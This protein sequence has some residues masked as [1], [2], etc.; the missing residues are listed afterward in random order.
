MERPADSGSGAQ[1]AAPHKLC[2]GL[3]PFSWLQLRRP[4]MQ[5]QEVAQA[6]TRASA[7]VATHVWSALK[8]SVPACMKSNNTGSKR[9]EFAAPVSGRYMPQEVIAAW[10]LPRLQAR[11]CTDPRGSPAAVEQPLRKQAGVAATS[12]E[13][14]RAHR[15]SGRF[16]CRMAAHSPAIALSGSVSTLF[17]ISRL[18]AALV[19]NHAT[20]P[21]LQPSA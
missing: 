11:E 4:C 10:R 5:R 20:P 9:H 18:T 15:A 1:A 17:R 14:L 19:A 16:C 7:E 6:Q 3:A 12:R 21:A 8:V 2:C 13:A